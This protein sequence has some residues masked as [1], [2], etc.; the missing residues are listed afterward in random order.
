MAEYLTCEIPKDFTITGISWNSVKS[1]FR[2][3]DPN[4]SDSDTEK[5]Y[6]GL[7]ELKVNTL[8]KINYNYNKIEYY[9]RE[10]IDIWSNHMKRSKD[11]TEDAIELSYTRYLEEDS[12]LT[13]KIKNSRKEI[14]KYNQLVHYIDTYDSD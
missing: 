7:L 9:E 6:N 8:E 11:N 10:K 12:T 1:Y 5:E 14:Q 2:G 4:D 3:F 13:L